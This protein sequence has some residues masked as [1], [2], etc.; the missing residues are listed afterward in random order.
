MPVDP[1]STS[2]AHPWDTAAEGW[3]RHGPMLGALQERG[4]PPVAQADLGYTD[5]WSSEAPATTMTGATR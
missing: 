3:D 4:G 1:A 2:P 5:V